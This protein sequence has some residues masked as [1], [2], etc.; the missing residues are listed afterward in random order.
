[1]N[2]DE[3]RGDGSGPSAGKSPDSEKSTV[4]RPAGWRA[5]ESSDAM[6]PQPGRSWGKFLIEKRID[7]GGEAE[8]YQAFDQAG[9]AGQVALKVPLQLGDPQLIDRWKQT[10]TDA[11][12]KLDHPHI[13]QIVDAG[14]IGQRPYV[15]TKLI[16]GQP[17]K[18]AI[19][20]RW[21]ALPKSY[22]G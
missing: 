12:K 18:H 13:V 4:V 21:P 6:S 16:E 15:A 17:L 14:I 19:T 2:A 20:T 10:E 5:P 22:G 9:A 3:V 8:I 11:L 7:A 1:M